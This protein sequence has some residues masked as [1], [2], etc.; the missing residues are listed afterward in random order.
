[1]QMTVLPDDQAAMP[2]PITGCSNV[3]DTVTLVECIPL[4]RD[5][6]S[7]RVHEA[8]RA[9]T[10]N[11][12]RYGGQKRWNPERNPFHAKYKQF[13]NN[14][15]DICPRQ[16]LYAMTLGFVHPVTGEEMYFHFGIARW[17]T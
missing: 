9:Y 16:A 10:F 2:S 13:V 8:H 5:A 15:F 11:D 14:C 7:N 6:P 3:W 12:E 1:M 17:M 4:K